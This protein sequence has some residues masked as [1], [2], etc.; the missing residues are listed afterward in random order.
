MVEVPARGSRPAML[1]SSLRRCSSVFS[2]IATLKNCFGHHA[3]SAEC[4]TVSE[5]GGVEE[6]DGCQPSWE[7]RLEEE[8]SKEGRG[9]EKLYQLM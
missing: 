8:S 2:A 9:V 7:F 5:E 1:V 4:R 3:V 6:E